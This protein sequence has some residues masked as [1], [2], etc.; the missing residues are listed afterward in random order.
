MF[1]K[2]EYRAEIA[3]HLS[4][5]QGAADYLVPVSIGNQEFEL[6]VDTGRYAPTLIIL[7]ARLLKRWTKIMFS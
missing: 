2:L 7:N 3:A 1:E 6:L 4:G 5:P